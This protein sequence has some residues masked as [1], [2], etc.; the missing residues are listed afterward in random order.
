MDGEREGFG[1]EPGGVC[2]CTG[3]FGV[4]AAGGRWKRKVEGV[5]GEAGFF[6]GQLCGQAGEH[7]VHSM[8][9]GTMYVNYVCEYA[10]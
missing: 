4:V 10:L 9:D 1:G 3:I 6:E 8:I 2:V 7:A 5:A